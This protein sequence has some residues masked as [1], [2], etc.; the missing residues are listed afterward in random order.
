MK[1]NADRP[2]DITKYLAEQTPVEREL[3]R[4]FFR[5]ERLVIFDIGACEGEDSIRY[6]RRFGSSRIFAFEPLP[7]NQ[8]IARANF[9]RYEARDIELV[10]LALSD[11]AGHASFHVSSGRPDKKFAGEEWNYGNKS[12]SLLPP[13]SKEPMHGWIRFNEEI[14]VQTETVDGFCR[15]QQISAIDFIHMDVQGAEMLVLAG[16]SAM[17][18]SVTSI[19]LEVA[20]QP[21]YK[22][23]KVRGEIESYMKRQG[24]TLAL[25][26]RREV[27]GDQFYVNTR[28][29]RVWSYLARRMGGVARRRL[30]SAISRAFSAITAF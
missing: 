23:Q 26:L 8:A 5:R 29:P 10:P 13:A 12:S 9:A 11:R 1:M 18:P 27:E 22:G 7:A 28:I 3:S 6:R 17:L 2:G 4:L 21:L 25:D 16:A 19:W 15:S 14:T 24:F 20:E 30:I